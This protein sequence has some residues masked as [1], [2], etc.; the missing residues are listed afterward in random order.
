MSIMGNGK[1]GAD[2]ARRQ[3]FTPFTTTQ[4]TGSPSLSGARDAAGAQPARI[5]IVEDDYFIALDSEA[6]LLRAGHEVLGIAA[7]G[8]QAVALALNARPDLII[9]D[10]RL[11]G[12]MD[13]VDAATEI[14][15]RTGIASIFATAYSN[16]ELKER[17]AP[18]DPLG[19]VSKP[20]TPRELMGAVNH[21]LAEVERRRSRH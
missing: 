2:A 19:W 13:G 8:E 16:P 14:Y 12:D 1:P 15:R 11:R 9:M 20:F 6:T 21:A 17:A 7:T 10:I 5:L 3:G 4:T 18:A